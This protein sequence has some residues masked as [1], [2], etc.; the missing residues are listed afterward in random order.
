MELTI[1]ERYTIFGEF[2]RPPGKKKLLSKNICPGE[3]CR[4][5][6]KRFFPEVSVNSQCR[7]VEE[8]RG[9]YKSRCSLEPSSLPLHL[10]FS[11]SPVLRLVRTRVLPIVLFFLSRFARAA[12]HFIFR[13]AER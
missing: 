9:Q 5:R 10:S 2:R 13:T 8:M 3:H 4:T 6:E 1:G 12:F 11:P 7:S